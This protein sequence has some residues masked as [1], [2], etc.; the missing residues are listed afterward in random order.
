MKTPKFPA[1]LAVRRHALQRL[2]VFLRG[3]EE[4]GAAAARLPRPRLEE[5]AVLNG[6]GWKIRYAEDLRHLLAERASSPGTSRKPVAE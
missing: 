3:I 2:L 1:F 4:G 6:G 5:G